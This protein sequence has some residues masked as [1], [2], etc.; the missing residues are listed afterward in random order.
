MTMLD[1]VIVSTAAI[2]LLVLHRQCPA[3]DQLGLLKMARVLAVGVFAIG[4]FYVIDL[5]A[6]WGL[7]LFIP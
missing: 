3:L 4:F 2:S 7:P 6:M 1:I 5:F